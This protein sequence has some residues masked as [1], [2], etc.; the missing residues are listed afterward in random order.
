MGGA[1]SPVT[2]GRLDR[3]WA[4]VDA[5]R[6]GS[7][8]RF[9]PAG[10]HLSAF[11]LGDCIHV[12]VFLEEAGCRPQTVDAEGLSP[13]RCLGRAEAKLDATDR[14][15]ELDSGSGGLDS[16]SRH[17]TLRARGVNL[18]DSESP[19]AGAPG[20]AGLR[21]SDRPLEEDG[22]G[23][24]AD[25]S[26]RGGDPG[27]S[28]GS[29][30]YSTSPML[31]GL[32]PASIRPPL[33]DPGPADQLGTSDGGDDEVGTRD[34]AGE[35][36]RAQVADRHGGVP[37]E[38]QH[39]H[40]SAENGAVTDDN[41][42]SAGEENV[43]GVEQPQDPAGSARVEAGLAHRAG[44]EAVERH[45]VDVLRGVDGLEDRPLVNLRGGRVLDENPVDTG[46]LRETAHGG[47]DLTGAG[48]PR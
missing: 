37:T 10:V 22:E 3:A 1:V 33:G 31:A 6:A 29:A 23:Y 45:A 43:V 46:V 2:Q 4:W 35:V 14:Q 36:P 16:G 27:G 28:P 40:G 38:Q 32:Q 24:R 5:A 18:P 44:R 41:R 9:D 11:F 21:R 8:A 12:L 30:T 42:A 17:V 47:D 13:A 15:R 25:A 34:L 7:S 48:R 20:H 39:R 26:R 19:G